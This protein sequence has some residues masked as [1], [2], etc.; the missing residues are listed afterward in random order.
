[1]NVDL[2]YQFHTLA[3]DIEDISQQLRELAPF[4]HRKMRKTRLSREGKKDVEIYN[5]VYQLR[6]QLGEL[7]REHRCVGLLLAKS[8]KQ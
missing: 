7:N 1:M 2:G 4:Y 5:K 8:S 6:A 3:M